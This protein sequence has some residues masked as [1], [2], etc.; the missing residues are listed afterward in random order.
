[1]ESFQCDLQNNNLCSYQLQGK[2]GRGIGCVSDQVGCV[3]WEIRSSIQETYHL[4]SY[5]ADSGGNSFVLFCTIKNSQGQLALGMAG[6]RCLVPFS[7]VSRSWLCF[8]FVGCLLRQVVRCGSYQNLRL[9]FYQ[10]KQF[11]VPWCYTKSYA[12][13]YLIMW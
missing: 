8:P 6:S 12:K 9:I 1:M 13:N 4:D 5:Q 10:L 7:F 11:Q 2:V 3:L